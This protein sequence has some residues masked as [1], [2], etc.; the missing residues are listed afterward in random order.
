MPK[1]WMGVGARTH[2]C[3]APVMGAATSAED[4]FPW[5]C[6]S[7]LHLSNSVV[8]NWEDQASRFP[9]VT[10]GSWGWKTKFKTQSPIH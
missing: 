10:A 7:G 1:E 2:V 9:S 5:G 8:G 3:L 6:V 4:L